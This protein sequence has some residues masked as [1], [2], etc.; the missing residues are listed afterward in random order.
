MVYFFINVLMY[1]ITIAFVSKYFLKKMNIVS[2]FLL[3]FNYN[4][5]IFML[6]SNINFLFGISLGLIT[7]IVYHFLILIKNDDK[8]C[9]LI[10]DGNI[11]FHELV[12]N[13]S[14]HKLVFELKKRNI[15]LDE[16][17]FCIKKNN[18]LVIIKNKHIK[19]YPVSIIVDG[20]L[21]EE[22]LKLVRRNKEWLVNELLKN[23]LLIRKVD[24]AYY[25]KDKIYFVT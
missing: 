13:Y 4:V 20:E 22:N 23:Q 18:D 24:Y 6:Y 11:N 17:A 14:F 10:K 7:I 5:A 16:I 3:L 25:K 15:K 21:L 2:F 9:I 12:T 19:N 8:E 1:L